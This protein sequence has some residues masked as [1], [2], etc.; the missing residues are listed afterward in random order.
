MQ[1]SKRGFTVLEVLVAISI[2]AVIIGFLLVAIHN[3][4]QSAIRLERTAWLRGRRMGETGRRKLPIRILFIGNS[5]TGSHDLPELI[6]AL[7]KAADA[8][9]VLEVESLIAGGSRLKTH[10]E[11]GDAVKAIREGEWDFVVLQEQSQTPLP[12]FG[13]DEYFYPYARKFH[14][15]IRETDAIT[16]FFMTW[17]RPDTPAPQ[18]AWTQSYLRITKELRAEVA[19]AGLTWERV[20]KSL[21][22]L[23]LYADSGGH[24][25]PAGA[26]LTAC[27]FYATIYDRS[28]EGLPAS[29]TT[30]SGVTVSVP[31]ANAADIQKHAWSALQFVK[32][33]RAQNK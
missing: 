12:R 24:P 13:R 9:P 5:Y 29:V 17:A 7:A 23:N 16:M 26:Y 20:H 19:P 3:T 30:P 11:K 33:R 22:G 28:P 15:V 1:T 31:P 2:V 14:E 6:K 32:H 21:P 27:T 4:R 10:W 25:S 18:S 8:K